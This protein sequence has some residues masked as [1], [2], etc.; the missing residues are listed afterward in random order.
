MR[1]WD[2]MALLACVLATAGVG[3]TESHVV[4]QGG[5]TRALGVAQLVPE[6]PP[7]T[8]VPANAVV[9][10][11]HE[12]M[13]VLFDGRDLSQFDTFI[14][15]RGLN[16]DPEQVFRVEDGLIHVSGHEMG[17]LLTKRAFHQ[18]YLR[19]EFKW[20]EGTFGERKGQARDSGILYSIQGEQ[21]VWPRS[22]EFQIKEGETGDFWMTD[23][24]R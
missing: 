21:K 22:I 23:G 9:I 16:S 20:G 12:P 2:A 19:A 17:Y 6:L 10:P 18:F 15:G 24:R 1:S 8:A 7:K 14:R 5:A 11:A 3:R 4:L 13:M